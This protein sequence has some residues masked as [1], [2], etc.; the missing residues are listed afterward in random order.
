MY[1]A[2]VFEQLFGGNPKGSTEKP[3][4]MGLVGKAV[5]DGGGGHGETM[6]QHLEDHLLDAFP[7]NIL[8]KRYTGLLGEQVT[9]PLRL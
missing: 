9:E 3:G 4:K 6:L 1:V 8:R 7:E 2:A 5:L